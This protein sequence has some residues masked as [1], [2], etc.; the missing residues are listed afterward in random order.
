M[1]K[2]Q[3]RISDPFQIRTRLAELL[4]KK[5][6]IV[7]NDNRVIFGKLVQVDSNSIILNNMR[8]KKIEIPIDMIYE[9]YLDTDA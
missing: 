4:S 2:R 6:N 5:I 9:L 8:L 1:Y 3:L 7:L